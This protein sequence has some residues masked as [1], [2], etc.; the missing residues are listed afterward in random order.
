MQKVK[1]LE[2]EHKNSCDKVKIDG[3]KIM[4]EE[5][6]YHVEKDKEMLKDKKQCKEE[7]V[8]NDGSN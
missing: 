3:Q 4:K 1:H 7:Y 8:K 6:V 5:R 2:Y